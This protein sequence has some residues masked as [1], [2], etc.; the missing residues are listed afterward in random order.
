MYGYLT[1][2][3]TKITSLNT[4]LAVLSDAKTSILYNKKYSTNCN[5][6]DFEG[7]ELM[8]VY[9]SPF[10]QYISLAVCVQRPHT[11]R[12]FAFSQTLAENLRDRCRRHCIYK[13]NTKIQI[14]K[15]SANVWLEAH[16]VCICIFNCYQSKEIY[17][18]ITKIA[19][20]DIHSAC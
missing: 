17:Q 2:T 9:I 4:S 16:K 3:L 14:G 12:Q 8:W 6:N 5:V 11:Y 18:D 13:I 19:Q 10:H 20:V 7:V 1:N 15:Q